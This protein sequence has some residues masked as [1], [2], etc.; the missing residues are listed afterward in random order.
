MVRSSASR[1]EPSSPLE[2]L[3]TLY[4][5]ACLLVG[6]EA[7]PHLLVR[8]VEKAAD[9]PSEGPED[10]DEWLQALLRTVLDEGPS[11]RSEITS[12]PED[13]P[14]SS[15]PLRRDA[16]EQIVEET[17]AL[18][19]AACPPRERFLLALEGLE[20]PPDDGHASRLT[21]AL[22]TTPS[23]ARARLRATFK[24]LLT[25]GKFTLVE[26]TL[27]DEFLREALDDILA[28]RFST[29]PTSLRVRL[30]ST[31][32]T[33]ETAENDSAHTQGSSLL[34]ERLPA[35]PTTRS[36][37]FIL[38]I[39]AMV[40]AGGTG[41]WYFLQP[42]ASSSPSS[43]SQ[44]L[45]AFSAQYADSVVPDVKTSRSAVAEAFVDSTWNRR[46]TVPSFDG[47]E[48]RGVGRVRTNGDVEVPVYLYT[49]DTDTIATFAYSYALVNQLEDEVRLSTELRTALAEDHRLAAD[50]ED[51]GKGLLWRDRDDIF[52]A[53][54]PSL[55]AD[56]LR[57]WLRP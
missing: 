14:V 39:G 13:E 22:D 7:A 57:T 18:A 19:L 56:S 20:E 24:A 4:P 54:S 40:L 23:E 26:E 3:D 53:V 25:E 17:L 34:L 35:G 33:T 11:P 49:A 52:V 37:L 1:S 2:H 41:L 10:L 32:Q 27:S 6:S 9:D 50:E 46:V 38:L 15:D 21:D 44:S 31:L 5:L 8:M 45:V 16:A 12:A 55:A 51:S 47:A 29:I 30:Q 28:N 43:S 48:L 42:S 36:L